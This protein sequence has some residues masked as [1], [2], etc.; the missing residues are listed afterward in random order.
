MKLTNGLVAFEFDPETGSLIQITDLRPG[1]PPPVLS[2]PQE[3]RLFRLFI[4]D[5]EQ[6]IDRYTDSHTSGRPQMRLDGDTLTIHY[7]DLLAADSAIPGNDVP[8][9]IRAS[10]RVAL[11]AGAD[12][13]LFTLELEERI[14]A[15]LSLPFSMKVLVMRGMGR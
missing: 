2:D 8:T 12:E 7:P 9:G 10:V 11:P 14:S 15:G 6:W 1:A 5:D 3:G 4:P 13:A